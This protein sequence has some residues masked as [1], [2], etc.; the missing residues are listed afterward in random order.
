MLKRLNAI[1]LFFVMAVVLSACGNSGAPADGKSGKSKNN[2]IEASI[3]GASYVLLGDDDGASEDQSS[4]G[5]LA[6]D[7]K[8]KNVSESSI[9]LSPGQDIK[10]YDGDEE[11]NFDG[12]AYSSKLDLDSSSSGSIGAGKSK[13]ITVYFNVNKDKT[14]EIGLSPYT[15]N[16]KKSK[17]LKLELDTKKY[18][19][20]F[21]TLQDPAKALKAYV[22]TIYFGKDNPDY[23]KY[24]A[25]DKE[26]VQKEAQKAFKDVMED[27]VD[28]LSDADAEKYYQS[29]K[30][31]AAQK[32]KIETET[33]AV[34]KGRAVVKLNYTT[35]PTNDL[36]D[37]LGDYE[38]EYNDSLA[39]YDTEKAEKYALSKFDTI[40]NAIEPE[41]AGNPLEI[42]MVLKDGKWSVYASDYNSK[43]LSEI[44]GGGRVY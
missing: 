18:S 38:D 33:E 24:T 35:I 26:T 37:K 27:I 10:L 30:S 4:A 21:K 41:E 32:V 9:L 36:Y 42:P 12:H 28:D 19:K 20:S 2:T 17:E 44:F 8:V 25:A 14:Y 43:E 16:G 40:V 11:V 22:E 13:T 3:A 6:V 23:E 7:L 31:A 5:T 34:A 15:D 29:Y 1:L 39:D